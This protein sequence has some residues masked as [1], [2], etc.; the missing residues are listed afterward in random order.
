[1]IM[2]LQLVALNLHKIK[3]LA[4]ISL[5]Q[6]FR[7]KR[8]AFDSANYGAG[9]VTVMMMKSCWFICICLCENEHTHSQSVGAA[10]ARIMIK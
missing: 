6:N 9:E 1:M 10:N 2:A 4:A 3:L 5:A 8:G 7:I